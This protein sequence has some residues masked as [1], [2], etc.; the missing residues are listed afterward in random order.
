M[1]ITIAYLPGEAEKAATLIKATQELLEVEKI[2]ESERHAP[3]TH[4]YITT[5][6]CGKT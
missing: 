6:K 5:K 3:Y 2:R 4:V 1:K